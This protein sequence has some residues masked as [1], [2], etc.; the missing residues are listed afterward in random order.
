MKSRGG[1]GK[2]GGRGG[3]SS[4]SAISMIHLLGCN[5]RKKEYIYITLI[6]K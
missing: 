2:G 6:E 3:G 5:W 1:V 4:S